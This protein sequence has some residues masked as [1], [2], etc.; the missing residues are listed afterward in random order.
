MPDFTSLVFLLFG[1]IPLGI[2][3]LG[4]VF[5]LAGMFACFVWA[6]S[7][8]CGR[9]ENAR[10]VGGISHSYTKEKKRGGQTVEETRTMH[11]TVYQY[12]D[13]D[14]QSK[15]TV[16]NTGSATFKYQTGQ[17]VELYVLPNARFDDVYDRRDHSALLVGTILLGIGLGLVISMGNLMNALGV[18][19]VSTLICLLALVVRIVLDRRS[20]V[21]HD[22]TRLADYEL[23]PA[24]AI[25]IEQM[26]R[27]A[28]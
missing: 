13:Q 19:L 25:P 6:W 2:L 21:R 5:C 22:S 24:L 9:L 20:T 18:G 27:S 23:D 28:H 12:R 8:L 10:V 11:C 15:M 1:E 16:R 4:T 3:L 14:G 26:Q 17:A 7:R